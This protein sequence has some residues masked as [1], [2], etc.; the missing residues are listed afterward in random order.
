MNMK[1]L[2]KFLV[3]VGPKSRSCFITPCS[4]HKGLPFY[5]ESIGHFYGNSGYFTEREHFWGYLLIYT[6]G[7]H[8][9]VK[10]KDREY[11]PEAGSCIFLNR[12]D[13]H[14]YGTRGESWDMYWVL[15]GGG[16]MDEYYAMISQYGLLA[17]HDREGRIHGLLKEIM[18]PGESSEP[19]HDVQ[20]CNL[21]C[22]LLT[23]ML[24]ALKDAT[25]SLG[26]A[27]HRSQVQQAMEFIEKNYQRSI[28]TE[29][30]LKNIYL[31]K[32]YFLR[33]FKEQTGY[34]LY[35]YLIKYRITASMRLLKESGKSI[36]QIAEEVGFGNVNNYIQAFKRI[37]GVTPNQFRMYLTY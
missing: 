2:E 13:Y 3:D 37:T 12:E 6:V 20:V 19:F 17:E 32:Y 23:E 25:A 24:F 14:Y 18:P 36:F 27:A 8:G 31:S 30:V 9:Y 11:F 33:L 22:S 7:G 4:F 29:D 34:S 1:T 10:I 21:L 26:T 15:C 5:V 16:S 35:E 28:Q